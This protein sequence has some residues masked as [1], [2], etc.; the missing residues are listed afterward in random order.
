MLRVA[1]VL[2]VARDIELGA[3]ATWYL[4]VG[5]SIREGLGFV[6]PETLFS[7]GDSVAT[8]NFPPLYPAFLAAVQAVFGTSETV[9][10]IAG[11]FVGAVT[12]VLAAS[13]A[14][15]L[16]GDRAGVVTAA[17]VALSPML[18]AADGSMMSEVMYVPLVTAAVLL[19]L[20]AGDSGEWWTWV[21]LGLALGLAALTRT[22]ALMLAVFLVLPI[23]WWARVGVRVRWVGVFGAGLVVL[24]VVTPWV[25]RNNSAVGDATISNVSP[26]TALAGSNCDRT[27]SGESLGSWEFECTQPGDRTRL[28]EKAWTDGIRADAVDYIGDNLDQLPLVLTARELRVWGLWEPADLVRRDAEETRTAW[29]QWLVRASAV[30]S[31]MGGVAGIWLMRDRGREVVVLLGPLA[32]VATTALL[33]HGNPR[34]RTVSEPELLVGMAV[35]LVTLWRRW[36]G[37]EGASWRT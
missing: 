4:L 30:V 20:R 16:A 26:A 11:A 2:F 33:S 14:R 12:V 36:R 15:H 24:L 28:G 31:L 34:F 7:T 10:Q 17:L 35:L 13:I 21:G 27:Y 29:F 32:M 8:A 23:L 9:S 1:Y 18:I 6:D 37:A 25:L 22:E 3:D 5:G 19:A